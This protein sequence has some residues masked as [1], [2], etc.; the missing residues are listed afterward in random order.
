MDFLGI[1][2]IELV[3]ATVVMLAVVLFLIKLYRRQS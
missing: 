2:W 3:I 1:G